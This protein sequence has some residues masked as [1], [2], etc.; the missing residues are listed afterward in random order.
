M[1]TKTFTTLK[2]ALMVS[3]ATLIAFATPQTANAN[4]ALEN[5][6]FLGSTNTISNPADPD[7]GPSY[8]LIPPNDGYLMRLRIRGDGGGTTAGGVI[9]LFWNGTSWVQLYYSALDANGISLWNNGTNLFRTTNFV[10][11]N[12]NTAATFTFGDIVETDNSVSVTRTW[13]GTG[14][15]NSGVQNL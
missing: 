1:K 10:S 4:V 13:T 3:A 12:T 2:T 14:T 5:E 9:P 8:P 6:V 15:D 7:F 11:K